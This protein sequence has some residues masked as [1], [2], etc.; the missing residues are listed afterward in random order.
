[1]QG[2]NNDFI[3]NIDNIS[4]LIKMFNTGESELSKEEYLT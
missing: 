2:K 1:L 3:Q 4:A